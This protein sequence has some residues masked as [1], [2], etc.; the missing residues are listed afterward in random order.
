MSTSPTSDPQKEW[1]D[2]V[3]ARVPAD[4]R[5][6]PGIPRRPADERFYAREY[7]LHS[8][9]SLHTIYDNHK[10]FSHTHIREPYK[11][12]IKQTKHLAI[13]SGRV[14]PPGKPVPGEDVTADI[15]HKALEIGGISLIGFNPYDPKFTYVEA[16]SWVR[17]PTVISIVYEQDYEDTQV[18]P[19]ARTE[20]AGYK[21]HTAGAWAMLKLAEYIRSRGYHAQ[22]QG[23][24][25]S[26]G[27]MQHYAVSAGLGQMGANG[28]LLSPSF[29]SRSRLGQMSTDAPVTYDQPR[30]FGT[31]QFCEKCQVCVG[32]CPGRALSKERIWWRGVF[33]FKAA[34]GRCMPILVRKGY[35]NCSICVRSC[36]IQKYGYDRVMAHYVETGDVLGKGTDE[37]EGYTLPDKGYFGPGKRP[38]YTREELAT[39]GVYGN[40]GDLDAE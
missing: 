35:D 5:G 15:R 25:R 36:P 34:S 38:I 13:A 17:Y 39:P 29:G 30:D 22:L 31:P 7:P 6:E 20:M 33:K 8:F 21:A 12:D 40:R 19:N 14:R 26:A 1:L 23:P 37:L 28:Q 9:R 11:E 3:E 10:I 4:L 24:F 2:E 18:A 27:I 16:R 32:R